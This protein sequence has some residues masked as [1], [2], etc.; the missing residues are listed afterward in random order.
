LVFYDFSGE[1]CFFMDGKKTV[2]LRAAVYHVE[3][4]ILQ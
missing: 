2:I 1:L 3:A 4:K